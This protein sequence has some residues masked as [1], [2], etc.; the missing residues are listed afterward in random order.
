MQHKKAQ[1]KAIRLTVIEG[2]ASMVEPVKSRPR[3]MPQ[4]VGGRWD[5]KE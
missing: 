4:G 5:P 1:C 2:T 3:G